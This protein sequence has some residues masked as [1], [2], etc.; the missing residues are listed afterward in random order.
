MLYALNEIPLIRCLEK[1]IYYILI[2]YCRQ[3][4]IKLFNLPG[5]PGYV[6]YGALFKNR[7]LILNMLSTLNLSSQS[8]Y[9]NLWLKIFY[10]WLRVN[11]LC[12]V[13]YEPIRNYAQ[14]DFDL[15]FRIPNFV[16]FMEMPRYYKTPN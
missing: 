2:T 12:F 4:K 8:N 5:I 13:F 1:T 14:Q 16:T 11:K 10:L 7:F 9:A 6:I 15:Q 3:N